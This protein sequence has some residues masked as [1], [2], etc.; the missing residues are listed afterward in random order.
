MT[1]I[2]VALVSDMWYVA[3]TPTKTA[4]VNGT[5][6]GYIMLSVVV[7]LGLLLDVPLDRTLVSNVY[8]FINLCVRACCTAKLDASFIKHSLGQCSYTALR[9][10]LWVNTVSIILD[11]LT[12]KF[13]GKY[14]AG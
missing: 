13:H 14:L 2:C 8:Q 5:L 11:P 10:G 4:V 12:G 6:V 9:L 3:M 1:I 7:M